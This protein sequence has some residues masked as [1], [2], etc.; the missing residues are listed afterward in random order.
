MMAIEQL[1]NGMRPER[2]LLTALGTNP[3][4]TTYSLDGQ[5]TTGEHAPLALIKLLD[6][7]HRPGRIITLLTPEARK[8]TWPNFSEACKKLVSQVEHLDIPDG[9]SIEEIQE[10]LQIMAK[11]IPEKCELMLDLTHGFRHVPFVLYALA[12]YLSS[13]RGVVIT[14]AW[15]GKTEGI[16]KDDPKPLIRID[17]LLELPKW[18]YAVRLFQDTGATRALSQRFGTLEA[19]LPKGRERGP[20]RN[21]M[22]ALT[23]FS[24]AYEEGM[25][26]ELGLEAAKLHRT[27]Q[28]HPLGE[29]PGINLPLA[30]DLGAHIKEAVT[31]W[32]FTQPEKLAQGNTI[33]KWKK[34][35]LTLNS[36]ELR[37]Q[38]RLVDA[39]LGRGQYAQALRLMRE[40][41]VSLGALHRKS[42]GEW[43]GRKARTSIERELGAIEIVE[44]ESR[45]ALT[46]EQHQWAQFWQVLGNLRNGIAHVGMKEDVA[47]VAPDDSNLRKVQTFW[48]DI[49]NA[50]RAWEPFGGGSGRLLVTPL[51]MSPGVLYSAIK[52]QPSV[53]DHIMVVA[54]KQAEPGITDALRAADYHNAHSVLIMDDPFTGY[55]ETN[56]LVKNASARL[57]NADNVDVNLTGGSTMM[58]IAAQ[59]L[60][61]QARSYQRPS[62]RFVL[63]DEREPGLQ[64]RNPWVEAKCYWLDEATEEGDVG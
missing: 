45:V 23:G 22:K 47:L 61:E 38:A 8:S 14:S 28:N 62:R 39:Y 56:M 51:G 12:L 35:G 7:E 43:L 24:L 31:P 33:G 27:M 11:A 57:L 37:R 17:S 13:F 48:N 53:P 9:N 19:A 52:A 58:G 42:A 50:D 20:A 41:V 44:R 25:P 18:L 32:R 55:E 63:V 21:A 29:L 60:F 54:S 6:E 34:E 49:K 16:P 36:D 1:N 40:W 5:Q 26:L 46:D 15:Y 3:R 10:L 59:K 30:D 4:P 64:R 2:I